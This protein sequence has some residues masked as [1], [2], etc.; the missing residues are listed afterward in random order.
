[1][2]AP[3]YVSRNTMNRGYITLISIL[4]VG[5]VGVTVAISLLALG[6]GSSRTSFATDQSTEARALANACGEE[7]LEQ[8]RGSTS[9]TGSG[10]LILG[11]GNCSYDVTSQ[12]GQNRTI[13]ASGNVGTIVRKVE[14][15]INQINPTIHVVSWQEVGDF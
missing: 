7:G 5:A 8:I 4:I 9:F 6:L 1:M 2:R 11:Q 10:N 15:N 3:L 12:G 13:A 14:I